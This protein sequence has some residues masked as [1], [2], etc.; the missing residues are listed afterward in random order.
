MDR[1]TSPPST[2]YLSSQYQAVLPL[3]SCSALKLLIGVAPGANPALLT[4]GT[5]HYSV[6]EHLLSTGDLQIARRN[7]LHPAWQSYADITTRPSLPAA[8]LHASA[9]PLLPPHPPSSAACLYRP[10]PTSASLEPPSPSSLLELPSPSS[11][12]DP[13]SPR[14]ALALPPR[15][16]FDTSAP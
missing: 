4:A 12:L 14:Y 15:P 2:R 8:A 16:L 5:N 11:A 3:Y 6:P 13:P 10:A 9:T 7:T 1:A